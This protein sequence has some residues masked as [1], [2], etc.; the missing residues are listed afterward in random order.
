MCLLYIYICHIL[1]LNLS[2]VH[3]NCSKIFKYIYLMCMRLSVCLFTKFIQ[4]PSEA[5]DSI[6]SSS[7]QELQSIVSHYEG[8]K[9]ISTYDH[10]MLFTSDLYFQL[11]LSGHYE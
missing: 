5:K 1:I 11:K 2:T 6:E 4:E 8:L 3:L 9:N 10:L 7:K